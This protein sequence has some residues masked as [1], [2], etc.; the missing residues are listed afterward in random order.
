LLLAHEKAAVKRLFLWAKGIWTDRPA[1]VFNGPRSLAW[2][3]GTIEPVGQH[4]QAENHK[5]DDEN[6]FDFHGISFGGE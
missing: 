5:H 1:P 4:K 2:T 3:F 6:V